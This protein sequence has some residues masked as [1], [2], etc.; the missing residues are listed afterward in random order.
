[1]EDLQFTGVIPTDHA[2]GELFEVTAD[3]HELNL[4]TGDLQ[5]NQDPDVGFLYNEV[6]HGVFPIS[7]GCSPEEVQELVSRVDQDVASML[8]ELAILKPED[9][10]D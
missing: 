2:Y 5:F 6:V 1:M 4:E 7:Y 10:V 9:F 8:R 3:T